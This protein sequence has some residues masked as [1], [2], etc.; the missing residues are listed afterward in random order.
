[1]ADE[2]GFTRRWSGRIGAALFGAIFAVLTL[3]ILHAR[4]Q[5]DLHPWHRIATARR[6]M[7]E[8]GEVEGLDF[9]G[10]IAREAKLFQKL[11]VE[12]E[13]AGLNGVHERFNRYAVDGLVNP[14]RFAK[15]WNR[16]FEHPVPDPRGGV[17]LVHGLSDSPYSMRAVAETFT[18]AGYHVV[19]L[20]MP[21]HGTVP[22]GLRVVSWQDFR[23]AYRIGVDH[24]SAQIGPDR[25]LVVVGYS[26]GAALAVE[27]TAQA[28]DEGMRVPDLVMLVS[29]ALRA[30]AVAAFARLQRWISELPGL[31][32]LAWTSISP[33]YD[34][35]KYNSFAVYAGE[36]IYSLTSALEARLAKLVADGR[37]SDFPRL[38]VFS[39]VVDATIRPWSV[40]DVLFDRLDGTPAELVLFDTNR[41]APVENLMKF[42]HVAERDALLARSAPGFDISLV[43][44]AND[45][46]SE[47][48]A[49]TR[50]VGD[51]AWSETPLGLGW[52]RGVYSLAHVALP[53]R[54]DDPLYGG[55]G[56]LPSAPSPVRLGDIELKG[57]LG[58]LAV[59]AAQLAR[60]RYNPFFTHLEE[61]VVST[62]AELD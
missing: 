31:E 43:T 8:I 47:L 19:G 7:H 44:N 32:K 57:E 17:L 52:P 40:V 50:R 27:Y 3:Y 49:R 55:A 35:Y 62:L 39:S 51:T 29:P 36:Q 41:L 11:E 13:A 48:V 18:G 37:M 58:V 22:S 42:D 15:N 21:G 20:R 5:P 28:I 12:V 56:V 53:F 60:L 45:V 38:L 61:R 14:A 2:R 23:T 33:E 30:P 26:N 25:P 4:A 46:S 9:R 16:S 6:I 34:P 1:M 10:Y 54:P 59:P 24:L